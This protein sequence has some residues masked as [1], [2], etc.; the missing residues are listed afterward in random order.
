[1]SCRIDLT[2]YFTND[3]ALHGIMDIDENG[4]HICGVVHGW[5]L[6]NV[7]VDMV[8]L[9]KHFL[10]ILDSAH[11]RISHEAVS[12]QLKVVELTEDIPSDLFMKK[13]VEVLSHL[14][15]NN[16]F[17]L[18]MRS[19]RKQQKA[20]ISKQVTELQKQLEKVYKTHGWSHPINVSDEE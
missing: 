19:M 15:E 7:F 8:T 2:N 17:V 18:Y 5:F 16:R 1:M 13:I 20:Q 11:P 10:S 9:F 3:T 14:L 6:V 4:E 12:K